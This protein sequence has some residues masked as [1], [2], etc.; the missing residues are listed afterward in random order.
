LPALLT[1]GLLL[2]GAAVGEEAPSPFPP[3][4]AES[5]GL[6]TE[7]LSNLADKVRGYLEAEQLVGGELLVIKN[8]RTVL[9]EVFGWRDREA[10]VEMTPDTIFNIRSMTKPLTSAAV[11]VLIDEGKLSLTDRAAQYI[12]GF[13]TDASRQITLEQLLTH[14]SGLPLS[15]LTNPRQFESLLAMANATGERGPEFP[16][17]SKFWYSDAG[18]DVLGAIVE[19]VSG[20]PLQEFWQRR[21]FTPLGMHD[22][23]VPLDKKDPRW[24]RIASSYIGRNGAWFPFWKPAAA[25]QSFYPFAWGSQTV[26]STPQDYAKFL[27]LWMDDGMAQS[28]RVLSSAAIGRMLTP[29]SEATGMGSNARMS[30]GFPNLATFYGQMAVL[31]ATSQD[32]KPTVIGHSGSD[33]TFAWAMPDED[34]MVLYFTQSRGGIS[35]LGLERWIDELLLHPDQPTNQQTS[36]ELYQ[37]VV[38]EYLADFGSLRDTTVKIFLSNERPAIDLGRGRVI[39]LRDPD[40]EGKWYFAIT[41]KTAVSFTRNEQGDIDAMRMHEGS[42]SFEAPRVGVEIAPQQDPAELQKYLGTYRI[43]EMNAPVKVILHNHRLTLDKSELPAKT[44]TDLFELLPPD[45]T[46]RWTYRI[47]ERMS[48]SFD[49]ADDGTVTALRIYEGGQLGAVAERQEEDLDPLPSVDSLMQL[50]GAEKAAELLDKIGGV[51]MTGTVTFAQSGARGALTVSAVG[52]DRYRNQIELAQGSV[53]QVCNP[54]GASSR[55]FDQ[56]LVHENEHL[57]QARNGHPLI[58]F[59][60][61]RNV[62]ESV[63]VIGRSEVAGREAF[64]VRTTDGKTSPATHW[65][66]ALS[67]DVLRTDTVFLSITGDQPTRTRFED[68][69]EVGGLRFPYRSISETRMAGEVVQQ[70]ENIETGLDLPAELFDLQELEAPVQ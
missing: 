52:T 17:G 70:I 50:R 68:F 2:A 43:E 67:G 65:V 27:A 3:A 66:D 25:T 40:A 24:E 31:W 28:Q 7:A 35:G 38:G 42:W 23:F 4:T 59:L 18:T 48:A 51:R 1:F 30:T 55:Y 63:E 49:Q 58:A 16:P 5:T 10:E 33:G 46:G 21:L 64:R 29:V 60:D 61:W 9:H 56:L 45:D 26:Y 69:R 39:E 62:Y 32:V 53:V 6:S 8:R 47:N 36:S 15:I 13:D 34:L 20:E 37:E 19:V 41:D 12:P 57:E 11:Q 14:R 44:P 22:S 54:D